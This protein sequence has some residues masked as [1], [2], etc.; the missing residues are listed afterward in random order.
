MY[1]FIFIVL[2]CHYVVAKVFLGIFEVVARVVAKV[3][4]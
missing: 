2:R 1:S 4:A 3:V